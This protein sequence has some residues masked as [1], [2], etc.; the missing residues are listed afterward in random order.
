M[1]IYFIFSLNGFSCEYMMDQ[2]NSLQ[3][4]EKTLKANQKVN[5]EGSAGS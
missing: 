3:S 1:N 2:F 5:A 4:Q